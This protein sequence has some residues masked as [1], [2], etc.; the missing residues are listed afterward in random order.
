MV[1][2]KTQQKQSKKENEIENRKENTRKSEVKNVHY[3]NKEFKE[4]KNQKTENGKK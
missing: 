1:I 2:Q 4:K 3:P